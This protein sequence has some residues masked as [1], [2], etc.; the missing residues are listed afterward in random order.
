MQAEEQTLEPLNLAGTI[1]TILTNEKLTYERG[2]NK[3][4]G[5]LNQI[6]ISAVLHLLKN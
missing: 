1:Q 3:Q 2:D 4:N 6:G 5:K